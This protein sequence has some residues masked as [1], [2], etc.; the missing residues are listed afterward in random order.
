MD[1]GLLYYGARFYI[2]SLARFASVDTIVPDPTNPQSFNRYSYV[3]NNP[4]GFIDPTGHGEC[5]VGQQ[6]ICE[7][8]I[9][10]FALVKNQ[11]ESG[12]DFVFGPPGSPGVQR[13]VK[14][15]PTMGIASISIPFNVNG[16]RDTE[17]DI[18]GINFESGFG[19]YGG[20][21]G[22]IKG[23]VDLSSFGSLQ[24]A[25]KY[26]VEVGKGLKGR[27]AGLEFG[28][29]KSVAW[30]TD[31]TQ[32]IEY[33]ISA[34]FISGAGGVTFDPNVT[35]IRPNESLATELAAGNDDAWQHLWA[36]FYG[37]SS[38]LPSPDFTFINTVPSD[39]IFPD[40]G[41]FLPIIYVH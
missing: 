24:F 3:R 6:Y 27:I 7:G 22:E 33:G 16:G 19:F 11:Y 23:Q 29:K 25:P 34:V 14:L 18:A 28:V 10:R 40:Y 37:S 5:G 41:G 13:Y 1:L 26:E 8:D 31:G 36:S 38:V 30:N 15:Q 35:I 32:N 20:L 17:L 4:L 39:P 9:D 21:G 12:D 2:P